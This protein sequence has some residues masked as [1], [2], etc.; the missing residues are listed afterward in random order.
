MLSAGIRATY[1][2]L[3]M[4]T[5]AATRSRRCQQRQLYA[6][7][8]RKSS[9]VSDLVHDAARCS[10]QQHSVLFDGAWH[11]LQAPANH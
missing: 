5:S 1:N 3:T 9:N 10:A 8:E 11:K 4:R 7:A 6:E 2:L